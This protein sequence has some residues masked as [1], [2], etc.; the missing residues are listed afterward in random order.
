MREGGGEGG[1]A[2]EGEESQQG[3][4][5]T[6][7]CAS[8]PRGDGDIGLFHAVDRD[9]EMVVTEAERSPGTAAPGGVSGAAGAAG[10]ATAATLAVSVAAVTAAVDEPICTGQEGEPIRLP[11]SS[12]PPQVYGAG[13]SMMVDDTAVVAAAAE[14]EATGDVGRGGRGGGGEAWKGS[15]IKRCYDNF[16][17]PKRRMRVY[18][19]RS[20]PGEMD[21]W[22]P[23]PKPPT[24]KT[25]EARAEEGEGDEGNQGS[26]E[27]AEEEEEDEHEVGFFVE[28]ACRGNGG[29]ARWGLSALSRSAGTVSAL[30]FL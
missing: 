11:P 18:C 19:F 10:P 25:E 24:E 8:L 29:R 7:C 17:G 3:D 4:A 6:M 23:T 15:G 28:E 30:F 14:A 2:G 13:M 1:G 12:S 9:V 21:G 26:E 16:P 5:A 20:P 22:V 27:V